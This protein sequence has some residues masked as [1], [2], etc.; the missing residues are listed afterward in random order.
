MP[1][2]HTLNLSSLNGNQPGPL[3]SSFAIIETACRS[4]HP[5]HQMLNHLMNF[6]SPVAQ[7]HRFIDQRKP[8]T[9]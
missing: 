3:P 8:G 6:V 7:H 9:R 1:R 2:T 5:D 4:I